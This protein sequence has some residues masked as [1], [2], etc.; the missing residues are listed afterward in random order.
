VILFLL[1]SCGDPS[2]GSGSGADGARTGTT[3]E[4]I[5]F[6]EALAQ[7]RGHHL[8]SLELYRAGDDKGAALHAGHPVSELL[9]SVRG[10][11][12]QHHR[13]LGAQLE[14]A[15]QTGVSAIQDDVSAQDLARSYERAAAATRRAEDAVVEDSDDAAYRGSVVAALLSTAGH[16]YDEAV[17]GSGI[18]LVVE[19]Q[20]AYAFVREAERLYGEIATDVRN[21]APEE[22]E[23]ID[24]AFARLRS[25]LRSPRPPASPADVLEVE[26][27]AEL[28]GHELEET[29][30]AALAATSDPADVA[31]EIEELLDELVK[32]YEAGDAAAAA[33]LSAEAY[34]ENYEVIEAEVIEKAPEINEELEPLLGAELRRRIQEGASTGDI[35]RMVAR[36]KDLLA[37]AVEAVS[38]A[39]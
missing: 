32:R 15:L 36:A 20:D 2:E 27:A 8:V 7:I 19:Y 28:V 22:A 23:E 31:A 21:R 11:L 12:D 30:G 35:R 5:A 33:E 26:S 34:L 38:E 10:E 16:E 6:G 25:A 13:S 3:A 4:A 9:A 37:R 18:D 1:A 17:R 24:D 39:D 14:S 29:M